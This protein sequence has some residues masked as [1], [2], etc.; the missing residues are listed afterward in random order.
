MSLRSEVYDF[1]RRHSSGKMR[2]WLK[3]RKWFMPLAHMM[4]ST[5]VYSSSYYADVERIEGNSVE[6]IARW[7]K[8]NL[9]PESLVDVGCGPG[10]MMEA[11]HKQGIRVFGV[12]IS[13]QALIRVQQRGLEARKFDLTELDNVIQGVPY[14]LAVSCEV[15]EHLK[16]RYAKTF[17]K[18]LCEASSTVYLTAAEPDANIGPGM[19]HF[20]EQPNNYWIQ[21]FN[22]VGFSLDK[23]KTNH[24]RDF[25]AQHNVISYL[26]R[27][28]IFRKDH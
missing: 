2:R 22:E 21:L 15:A 6:H 17:V 5:D 14:D 28:M 4:F 7:V 23:E 25:L 9:Q 27:P 13:E 20:N 10:H 3:Q 19:M 24:A 26:S 18:K 12:D 16:K 8:N 11:F 1:M